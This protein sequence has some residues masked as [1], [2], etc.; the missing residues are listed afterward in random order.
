MGSKNLGGKR[1]SKNIWGGKRKGRGEK[2][3]VILKR[4][5]EAEE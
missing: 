2:Y 4:K 5:N 3:I 1:R